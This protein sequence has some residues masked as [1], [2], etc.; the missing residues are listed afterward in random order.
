MSWYRQVLSNLTHFLPLLLSQILSSA[1]TQRK[2]LFE[3][4]GN[5][6]HVLIQVLAILVIKFHNF[7][8]LFSGVAYLLSCGSF[9]ILCQH[10]LLCHHKCKRVWQM[11]EDYALN[12][13]TYI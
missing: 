9:S 7:Q 6:L 12:S 1:R 4:R 10:C 13:E 5:L 8:F 3:F 11:S 2:M